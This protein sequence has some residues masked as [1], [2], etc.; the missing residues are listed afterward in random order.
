MHP[1]LPSFIRPN[2]LL[3]DHNLYFGGIFQASISAS[4]VGSWPSVLA[5]PSRHLSRQSLFVFVR[6]RPSVSVLS[7]ASISVASF[8]HCL[9][10]DLISAGRLFF[11]Q[12]QTHNSHHCEFERISS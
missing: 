4:V 5:V 1:R 9:D 3:K 12:F 6:S 2:S 11:F 7:P 8:M 10:Q